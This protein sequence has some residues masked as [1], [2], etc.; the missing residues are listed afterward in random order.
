ML[1]ISPGAECFG[2]AMTLGASDLAAKARGNITPYWY[3][4]ELIRVRNAAE[5][6]LAAA[7]DA[8]SNAAPRLNAPIMI[9]GGCCSMR[10]GEIGGTT[11]GELMCVGNGAGDG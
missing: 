2:S 4:L 8:R 11:T 3:A 6:T 5:R 7:D 10:A 9:A 1:G